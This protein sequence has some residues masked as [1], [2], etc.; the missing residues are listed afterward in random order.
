VIHF[1]SPI[2]KVNGN[3]G[4]HVGLFVFFLIT[5]LSAQQLQFFLLHLISVI[6]YH[7]ILVLV[8]IEKV[9]I[10]SKVKVCQRQLV[11]KITCKTKILICCFLVFLSF[12]GNIFWKVQKNIKAKLILWKIIACIII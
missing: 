4:C 3:N 6:M 11:K 8:S 2:K 7:K 10:R 9:F 5:S 1:L 12:I